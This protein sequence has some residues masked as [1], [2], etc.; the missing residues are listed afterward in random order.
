M[1]YTIEELKDLIHLSKESCDDRDCGVCVWAAK[2]KRCTLLSHPYSEKAAVPRTKYIAR[3]LIRDII[4]N[5]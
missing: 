5:Q 1:K 3:E 4:G 2:N